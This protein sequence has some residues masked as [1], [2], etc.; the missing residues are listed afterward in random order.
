MP[1]ITRTRCAHRPA[2]LLRT[3][4]SAMLLSVRDGSALLLDHWGGDGGGLSGDAYLPDIPWN[5]PSQAGFLDGVPVAYTV[6]GDPAFK[7]P[8]LVVSRQ[9]GTSVTQLSFRDDHIDGDT[10]TLSFTDAAT[11]LLVEH[12]FTV[13]PGHD[14]IERDTRVVNEGAAP[15]RV[16]R[17]AS[18]VLGLPPDRYAA[19]TLRG[20]W[21][22]EY[23]PTRRELAAG[24]LVV[25][26]RRGFTSHE[27]NPWFAITRAE[28]DDAVWFGALAWSGNWSIVIEA[29]RN[30]AVHVVAGVNPFDFAWRLDPGE[31]FRTPV[32]VCGH[33]GGGLDAAARVLHRYQRERVLPA[34]HR[35]TPPPVHFNTWLSTAFDIEVAHQVTLA[36]RAAELGAELFVVDDGWFG[37]RVDDRAGLGDWVVDPAKFP[38]GLGELIGAVNRLGM[39]FGIWLE[40]EMVNPDSDLYRAHPDW[41][42]HLADR[43]P[44]LSRNQLVL[45]FG[46]PE[47]RDGVHAQLRALLGEHRVDFVKWDHN[48]PYTEVGWPQAPEPREVW[49]RHVRGV[50]EVLARLRAEFPDLLIETCAGGGGRVDMGVLGLADMAQVSDNTDPSDRLRIQY[51]YSRAYPP[52]TMVG[53][54]SDTPEPTTGRVTPLAFRFHVAMQGVL[55]ISGDILSWS[56]EERAQARELIAEYKRLRPTIADGE[57]HWLLPPSDTQPCA[58]QYVAPD[59]RETV[60]FVY[61][62]RGVAGEGSRRLRLRGL[63]PER[64]Y[65]RE[66]DGLLSTGAALMAA[67]VPAAFPPP[68]APR[69]TEDWR[70]RIEVWTTE[71]TA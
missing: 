12:R 40:P 48:R 20:R 3:A 68:P 18:A 61:Q 54:V 17:V 25:D 69:H 11:G 8:G 65:R 34:R 53:W 60:L 43:E 49:V 2:W 30:E 5:R 27:A 41:V 50:Y 57:Q 19:W 67:G 59:R 33:T 37:A 31:D 58:V 46:R 63:V 6:H 38:R 32:L 1:A 15:L 21:G 45:N 56:G 10:L 47:V 55:G 23:Q 44:T 22:E 62:V 13:L 66:S 29:E 26:S 42:L 4:G 39:R 64:R 71:E 35:A 9:D 24:K 51:G 7:E 70:S 52:R 16:E 28:D 14:V 36:E